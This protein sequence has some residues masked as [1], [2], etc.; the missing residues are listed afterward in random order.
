MIL[1]K[2]KGV[3]VRTMAYYYVGRV[4]RVTRSWVYLSDCSW[5]AHAGRLEEALTKGTLRS[6]E[7]MPG[8]VMVQRGPITDVSEW[9]HA[10]PVKSV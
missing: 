2:G 9:S 7:R 6:A 10:L 3:F 8:I 4:E 1:S 5:V